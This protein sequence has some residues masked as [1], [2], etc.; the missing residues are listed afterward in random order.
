M[1]ETIVIRRAAQADAPAV[2]RLAAL[3]STQVPRG[4]LLLAVVDGELR[5]AL[6][7]SGELVADPFKRTQ[8]LA[9][10]LRL[11]AE[12]ERGGSEP[13]LSRGLRHRLRSLR[14][15]PEGVRA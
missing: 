3:D 4:E 5:A 2:A 12:Q 7:D 14:A 15:Q 6:S 9:A 8:P 1:Q 10:M 13:S 11:R